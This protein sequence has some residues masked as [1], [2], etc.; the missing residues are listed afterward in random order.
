[1]FPALMLI[2][3]PEP[4]FLLD[5]MVSALHGIPIAVAEPVGGQGGRGA[6]PG[7]KA[8]KYGAHR[9]FSVKFLTKHFV[10]GFV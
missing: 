5:A 10:L 3:C 7:A 6:P 8:K 1:M 2:Q 9:T 4:Y